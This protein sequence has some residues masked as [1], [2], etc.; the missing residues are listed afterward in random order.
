MKKFRSAFLALALFIGAI[1]AFAFSRHE[2]KPTLNNP[3]Y[4]WSQSGSNPFQGTVSDAQV[5]YGCSA[6]ANVCATGM[7]VPGQSGPATATIY[8][9]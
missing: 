1:G 5:H 3:L 8:K 2:S 7:L 4:N 9:N 6:V